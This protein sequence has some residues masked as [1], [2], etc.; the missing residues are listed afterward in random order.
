[1]SDRITRV[2]SRS[3]ATRAVA[4]DISKV[5]DRAW[6]AGFLYKVR[7]YGISG[8]IFGSTSF[9]VGNRQFQVVNAETRIS[10]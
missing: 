8:Q 2:F 7:S 9:F 6:H 3:G 4:L 1:M 5:F 10:S